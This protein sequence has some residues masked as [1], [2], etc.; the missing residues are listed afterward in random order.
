MIKARNKE[1]KQIRHF[2]HRPSSLSLFFE[3]SSST[4]AAF[5]T[6]EMATEWFSRKLSSMDATTKQVSARK[7]KEKDQ[8]RDGKKRRL[9]WRY[10][11]SGQVLEKTQFGNEHHEHDAF[12]TPPGLLFPALF[13]VAA[14]LFV[15]LVWFDSPFLLFSSFLLSVEDSRPQKKKKRAAASR[16]CH[17]I[18]GRSVCF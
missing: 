3:T 16:G 11:T 2:S 18:M 12:S 7:K 10:R 1:K 8:N 9:P 5:S 13:W 15:F 17:V 6:V 4:S 14:C